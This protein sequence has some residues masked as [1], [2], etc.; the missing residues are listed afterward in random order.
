MSAQIEACSWLGPL[1]LVMPKLYQ[2]TGKFDGFGAALEDWAQSG[3]LWDLRELLS[4]L[5]LPSFSWSNWFAG[6][7]RYHI[8]CLGVSSDLGVQGSIVA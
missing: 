1:G 6:S 4:Q 5:F 3:K 8:V 7:I 2:L